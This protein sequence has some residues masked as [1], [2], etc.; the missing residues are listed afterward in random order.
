M[1][2]T[3]KRTTLIVRDIRKSQQWYEDVLGMTVWMDTDFTLSGQGLAAGKAGD[4]THLTIMQAND[5]T[6]GMIGLLA[7]FVIV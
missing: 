2:S 5:P 7:W 1:A 3:I 4:V 6:I